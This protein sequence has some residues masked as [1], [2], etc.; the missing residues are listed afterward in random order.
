MKKKLIGVHDKMQLSE[1][2]PV[3]GKSEFGKLSFDIFILASLSKDEPFF[4]FGC[5]IS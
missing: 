1:K 3:L 4:F 2:R 5:K